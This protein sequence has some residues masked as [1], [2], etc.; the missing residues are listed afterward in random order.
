ME[1][2]AGEN[3]DFDLLTGSRWKNASAS[4]ILV[5]L[6]R[7]HI[8]LDDYLKAF[9]ELSFLGNGAHRRENLISLVDLRLHIVSVQDVANVLCYATVLQLDL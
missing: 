4:N 7:V 6:C 5:T 3:A 8:E 9:V 2:F 1:L